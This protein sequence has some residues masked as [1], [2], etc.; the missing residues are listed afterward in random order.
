MLE[1]SLMF[2]FIN[3]F[4]IHLNSTFLNN[5]FLF[6]IKKYII[7]STLHIIFFIF[8]FFL[9]KFNNLNPILHYHKNNVSE[10]YY[11]QKKLRP[12]IQQFN[13]HLFKLK[14]QCIQNKNNINNW[15]LLSEFYQIQQ[16]YTYALNSIFNALE[17]SKNDK[18]IQLQYFTIRFIISKGYIDNISFKKIENILIDS[19]TNAIIKYVNIYNLLNKNQSIIYE[20]KK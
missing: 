8:I 19:P 6:K 4:I 14:Y 3:I 16:N 9:F 7:M 11:K 20:K 17:L 10:I 13:K 12:I 18:K 15:F 5:F 1:I 2:F